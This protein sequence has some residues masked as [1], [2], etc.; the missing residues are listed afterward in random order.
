MILSGLLVC[1]VCGGTLSIRAGNRGRGDQR[2]GC[3]RH[4]RRGPA[5]CDNNL[6]VRRD[7]AEGRIGLLLREK[8]YTPE[9]VTRLIEHVNRRL[10]AR[11]E[12]A[13]AERAQ[14]R[15]EQAQIE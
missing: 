13:H 9:A 2:Y 15:N 8:L 10:Q 7:L 11:Q 1:G 14:L 6:L 5:A 12:A 4:W 3:T